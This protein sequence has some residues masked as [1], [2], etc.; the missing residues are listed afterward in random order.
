MKKIIFLLFVSIS[1]ILIS[2]TI[3]VNGLL[4]EDTQFILTFNMASREGSIE[5][6]TFK[7]LNEC[8]KFEKFAISKVEIEA[9]GSHAIFTCERGKMFIPNRV[10]AQIFFNEKPITSYKIEIKDWAFSN[11]KV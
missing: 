1:N 4:D 10:N 8:P 11:I 2:G 6:N 7:N 3:S 5:I 9:G